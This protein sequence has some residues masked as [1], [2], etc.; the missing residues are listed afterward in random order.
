MNAPPLEIVLAT[1]NP[2]K[3]EE[4]AAIFRDLGLENVRLLSLAEASGATLHEPEE[5]GATFEQNATIKAMSYAEQTGMLCLADDSGIEIDALGG[6]PGVISSHY[7]TE[8]QE[9]GMSRAERDAANNARVMREMEGVPVERRTARFVCVMAFASPSTQT[10]GTGI[11]PVSTPSTS[12]NGPT[13]SSGTGMLPV[14]PPPASRTPTP[15]LPDQLT[16][17]SRNLPH[18]QVGGSA[19]FVTFRLATGRLSESERVIVLN[20]CKH[21]DGSRLD[22]IAAVVMPDHVHL[23][24]RPHKSAPDAFYSLSDLVGGIQRYS[25]TQINQ[26]RG[27]SGQLWQDESFDRI[28]RPDEWQQTWEYILLNPVRAGLAATPW[29]YP[30][31]VANQELYRALPAEEESRQ[32]EGGRH[33]Q[34][35][36]ATSLGGVLCLVRGTFEG[37]IGLPGEVPRGENGFGYDPLFLVAPEFRFTGAEMPP[38]EKN[39]RSHRAMAARRMAAE[40]QSL[41]ASGL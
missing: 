24:L 6:K 31:L 38:A 10:S 37:R 36:C 23:M 15:V 17:H 34:H 29:E 20:A 33:R 3:V 41:R 26:S 8:G 21:W 14:S 12:R 19:Y 32:G 1:G 9:R 4:L 5:T 28:L 39:K 40:I 2:H 22:L 13:Q 27:S 30:Y 25:S 16:I 7:C 18:W 35:A 11:L